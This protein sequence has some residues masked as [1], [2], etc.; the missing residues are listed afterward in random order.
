MPSDKIDIIARLRQELLP[1][2][3]FRHVAG[4]S[5]PGVQLGPI[6]GHF[7]GRV[8]PLGAVHEWIGDEAA[9]SGF[10]AGILAALMRKGGVILWISTSRTLF[11]PALSFFGI[12]PD[13]I[14]FI[15]LASERELLWVMEEA[16]KCQSLAA[17]VGELRSLPFTASRRLQLAVEQSQVTGFILRRPGKLTTTACVT[18]WKITALPSTQEEQLPGIGFPVWNVELLKV[19]NGR[20]GSWQ[21]TWAEGMFREI[22]PA[23]ALPQRQK[24][25]V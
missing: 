17:V 13:Q 24:K 23:A 11:P 3:G 15:D 19:R 4:N 18:R 5:M 21:L 2:Q 12:Q 25:I 6:N 16:L 8:F 14:I 1:L 20:P 10:V 9:S 22:A 7:P